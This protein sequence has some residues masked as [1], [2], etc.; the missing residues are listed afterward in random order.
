M[1]IRP[2]SIEEIAIPVKPSKYN[3][4]ATF[5]PHLLRR[6]KPRTKTR[7]PEKSEWIIGG[8][9]RTLTVG[10]APRTMGDKIKD[11]AKNAVRSVQR[12]LG[13]KPK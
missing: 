10:G 12:F 4:S 5:S 7:G 3:E 6:G 9:I 2:R 13:R 11:G 1:G 8:K